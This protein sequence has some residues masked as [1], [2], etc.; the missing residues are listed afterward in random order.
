MVVSMTSKAGGFA[1]VFRTGFAAA[2][3]T[4]AVANGT[5]RAAS[6]PRERRFI[7][8]TPRWVHLEKSIIANTLPIKLRQRTKARRW[9]PMLRRLLIRVG[10]FE[11]GR[12]A[13]RASQQTHAGG[14]H[15]MCKAHG[16]GD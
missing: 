15:S 14:K 8:G 11:Q 9:Q 5:I 1:V 16:N 3:D 12:L 4:D 7:P 6:R 2:S 10:K 13:E